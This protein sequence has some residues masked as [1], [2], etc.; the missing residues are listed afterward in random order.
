MEIIIENGATIIKTGDA[1]GGVKNKYNKIGVSKYIEP[2]GAI[3]YR[4]V[5]SFN[6]KRYHLG[7]RNTP[8]EAYLLRLEAEN[9]LKNGT[10]IEWHESKKNHV[11]INR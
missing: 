3:K 10:F 9:H 7:L 5:I 11:H 6:K 1:V 2:N 4:A 8:D